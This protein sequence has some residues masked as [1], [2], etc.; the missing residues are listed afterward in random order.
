MIAT[1]I[2][3]EISY[4]L[5]TF[6][7]AAVEVWE[8]IGNFIPNFT[9]HMINYPWLDLSWSILV[10]RTLSFLE[11]YFPQQE[12]VTFNSCNMCKYV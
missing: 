8:V 11:Y 1:I 9:D 6:N 7:G 2:K 3:C 10:K 12:V 4:Q 5:P